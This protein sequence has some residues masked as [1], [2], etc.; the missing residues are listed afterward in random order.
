LAR[1]DSSAAKP[2]PDLPKLNQ[3]FPP[4]GSSRAN[5]SS[6][7]PKPNPDSP[8]PDSNPAKPDSYFP[9]LSRDFPNPSHYFPH[10]T[11]KT[12][13]F[14]RN[15]PI[16]PLFEPNLPAS[17]RTVVFASLK[18]REIRSQIPMDTRENRVY[19]QSHKK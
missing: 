18:M 17:R 16:P 11:L 12:S 3:D 19:N 2:N 15:R 14:R 10:N 7:L 1:P 6:D 4:P 5:P 8:T 13:H 9:R